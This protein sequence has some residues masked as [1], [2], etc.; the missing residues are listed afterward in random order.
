MEYLEQYNQIKKHVRDI[1]LDIIQ[2]RY[3]ITLHPEDRYNKRIRFRM[4]NRKI[5]QY[6]TEIGA[7][8]TGSRALRCYRFDGI[9]ILNRKMSDWDFLITPEMAMKVASKFGI[10]WNLVDPIISVEGC[11]YTVHPAYSSSYRSGVVDVHMIVREDFPTVMEK[12]GIRFSDPAYIINEKMKLVDNSPH[13]MNK[14]DWRDIDKETKDQFLKQ[15]S[16]LTQMVI[17]F[18]GSEHKN[19]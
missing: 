6:L 18:R 5:I 15:I 4:P 10:K 12:D 9:R 2:D 7:V 3:R 11:R 19:S 17:N 13:F 8:L 14:L 16:D 1:N